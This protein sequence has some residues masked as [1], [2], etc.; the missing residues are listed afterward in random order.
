MKRS[1]LKGLKRGDEIVCVWDDITEDPRGDVEQAALAQMLTR[2]I[3]LGQKTDKGHLVVCI[4]MTLDVST[5]TYYGVLAVPL[6]VIRLLAKRGE[7]TE[8]EIH[9]V[10]TA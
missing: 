9:N 10:L 7:V 3:Y 2:G 8:Q 6:G 5:N 1:A 4:G